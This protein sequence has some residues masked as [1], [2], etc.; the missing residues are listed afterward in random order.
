MDLCLNDCEAEDENTY[1]GS[2]SRRSACGRCA[3]HNCN[4]RCE[5]KCGDANEQKKVTSET[6][7]NATC[8]NACSASCTAKV[9]TQ[10]QVDCQESTYT[11][12][13]QK[14]VEQCETQCT[15]KGGAIFCNGQFVNATNAQS[16]ADELREKVEIDIDI[17]AAVEDVGET[18]DEATDSACE[19]V[20]E[21]CSVRAAGAGTGS[22]WSLLCPL[23]AFALWRLQ[24]R[25]S[26]R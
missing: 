6:E 13:E 16:C 19:T 5:A 21:S 1:C 10:C 9:N 25:R 4:K 3:K 20:N 26:R 15:D 18:V 2:S 14:M 22:A 8:M 12:C 17:E 11:S 24:R 7:C 23:G